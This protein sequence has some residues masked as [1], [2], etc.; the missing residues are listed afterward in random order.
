M[1]RTTVCICCCCL[2]SLTVATQ[3]QN[4]AF[5]PEWAA[6]VSAG[7]TWAS[8]V[9]SPKVQQS[10]YT[11][12]TG[13]LTVRWITEKN[14][15]IQL[16]V[17]LKQQGWKENFD[18]AGDGNDYSAYYYRRRMNYVDIPFLTHIYFGDG[19]VNFFVNLGPQAGFLLGEKTASNLNGLEPQRINDQ[20]DMPA[21]K[22][23][24]WGIGGGPGVELRTGAGRFLLEGRY[25]YALSDFYGTRRTDVFGKASAQV[26]TLKITYLVPVR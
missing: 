14:L 24:E 1:R 12:Y 13:G 8:A 20:H 9:F 4:A 2:L 23:F 25:Y 7:M 3:A 22:S 5:R 21:S 6:G 16:E 15:G 19:R 26:F 18:E 17:N 10:M 11:G